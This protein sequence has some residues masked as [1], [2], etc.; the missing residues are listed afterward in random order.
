MDL[1]GSASAVIAL[2]GGSSSSASG[3]TFQSPT[4]STGTGFG[5]A[6][7]SSLTSTGLTE[8]STA[9][10]SGNSSGNS[11]SLPAYPLVR[12]NDRDY[13]R[14]QDGQQQYP[15]PCDLPEMHRQILRSLMLLRVFGAPFCSPHLADHPPRRV[16]EIACGSGV[17]SG[18]CHDYF[19]RRG[20]ANIQFTGIDLVAAAPDLRKRGVHWQFKRHDLRKA[21]LPFP[22]G[23]FDFVFIKDTGAIPSSPAQQAYGLCEPLR[24]LQPGGTLEVWDSDW[25][26]R[27]L[28]PN[29]APAHSWTASREQEIADA[30]ATYTFTAATPFTHAQ[31]PYLRDYNTWVE[32]AF[33]R[34]KLSALPCATIGLSFT[35]EVDTFERVENRRI[36][37]PLS[38]MR[39]ER[40]Q[41]P[42]PQPQQS[43]Q[44]QQSTARPKPPPLSLTP[45]Q[46]AI[47][48]TALL[49]VLQ[50]IEGLEPML[51]QASGKSRDEW[52]RWWAAMTTDL[53]YRGGLAGGECLEV[54][55]WW[56]RK[57]SV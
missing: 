25:V 23:Y 54:S 17:W 10:S 48:R 33:D 14:D 16:L 20:H 45:E 36:A 19:A 5:T 50:M 1:P 7:Q 28:L 9:S 39:W 27:S 31:N 53:L 32:R 47:R 55:A 38:E 56:G 26:F 34:R 37:I 30:T 44:S 18:L 49:T 4:S 42:Q 57:S 13:L 29:P 12:L 43:Q 15:L 11:S 51:M 24:V 21:R 2:A 41:Q 52:D 46:I 6:S 35:A 8:T 22:D 3:S 40:D